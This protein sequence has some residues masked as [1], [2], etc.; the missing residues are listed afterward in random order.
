MDGKTTRFCECV[1]HFLP[2]HSIFLIIFKYLL[3]SL[4]PIMYTYNLHISIYLHYFTF[5]L[6]NNKYNLLTGV[7][8]DCYVCDGIMEGWER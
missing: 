5:C 3:I 7:D 4:T 8:N 1:K 2:Y 6:T